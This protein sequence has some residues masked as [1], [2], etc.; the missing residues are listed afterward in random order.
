MT[1]KVVK[2][3]RRISDVFLN[4]KTS[5]LCIIFQQVFQWVNQK[6]AANR[7]RGLV[8]ERW[9]SYDYVYQVSKDIVETCNNV[10]RKAQS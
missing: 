4:H 9:F 5:L 1:L 10:K 7:I 3:I 6:H 2:R 8:C